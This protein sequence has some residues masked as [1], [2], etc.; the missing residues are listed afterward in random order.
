MMPTT[1]KM[2]APMK[3]DSTLLV[4]SSSISSLVARGVTLVVAALKAEVMTPREKVVTA[5]M[6]EAMMVSRLSTASGLRSKGSSQRKYSSTSS[7]TMAV[8]IP[9]RPYATTRHHSCRRTRSNIQRQ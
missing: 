5:S 7:A 6:L 3:V 4:S 2:K 1:P 8:S 9:A